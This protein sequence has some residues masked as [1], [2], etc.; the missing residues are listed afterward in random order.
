MADFSFSV[1]NPIRTN[2]S[3]VTVIVSPDAPLP[4][5]PVRFQLV[6]FDEDNNASEPAFLEVLIRDT[7]APTAVLDGPKAVEFGEKFE[8][9]GERSSDIKPGKISRYEWTMVPI[10]ERPR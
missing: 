1:N 5:G 3:K 9:S 8:L 2:D 4:I 6:V 7:K 10:L